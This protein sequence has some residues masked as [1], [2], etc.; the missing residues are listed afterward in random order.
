VKAVAFRDTNCLVS[1]GED[2]AIIQWKLGDGGG[3]IV[4]T[5]S[6]RQS[7]GM[8]ISADTRFALTRNPP[9]DLT[10]VS[11]HRG[12]TPRSWKVES[13]PSC[14]ALSPDGSVAA[15]GDYASICLWHTPTGKLMRRIETSAEPAPAAKGAARETWQ[16]LALAFSPDGK[17]LASGSYRGV[18]IFEL[19]SGA[20][21]SE[22][23]AGGLALAVAF[24]HDGRTLAVGGKGGIAAYDLA[25]REQAF[26][27]DSKAMPAAVAFS[28][29][30]KLLASG[31]SDTTIVLW[32][33]PARQPATQP[34]GEADKRK[35]DEL[36]D[37]LA[38]ED[39]TKAEEAA[40]TL[41][42][43]GKPAAALLKERLARSPAT[44]PQPD[45]SQLIAKLD[46]AD[47]RARDD[48]FAKLAA[49]G[50]SAAKELRD[51]ADRTKS[52]EVR[53]RIGELLLAVS[54]P[55]VASPAD[56]RPTRAV[57]VL[58]LIGDDAAM[59]ALQALSSGPPGRLCEDTKA[60]LARLTTRAKP[61]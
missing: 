17:M 48:A 8:A 26:S 33:V 56:R 18:R 20:W 58:E 54:N 25:S 35:L 28:P 30:G 24:S 50:Q 6:Q 55:Y 59:Q 7:A 37:A 41:V 57:R 9:S 49:L 2:E 12:E 1:A 44:G 51:A 38:G 40:W 11:L 3:T 16:N 60:A 36:W 39:A 29:D 61:Q 13:M 46:D 10:L 27:L 5:A 42:R 15:T 45:V 4:W 32:R 21:A 43:L 34:A 47:F 14:G 19:A 31:H 22:L 52:E 23:A 53:A